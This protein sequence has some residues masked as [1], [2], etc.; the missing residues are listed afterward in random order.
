MYVCVCIH[1]SYYVLCGW[2]LSSVLVA[3][4]CRGSESVDQRRHPRDGALDPGR[5]TG[6]REL[7]AATGA[8]ERS[9]ASRW[10][11][12]SRWTERS[13]MSLWEGKREDD[14]RSESYEKWRR[15]VFCDDK[16]WLELDQ[17]E[18]FRIRKWRYVHVHTIFQA[19]FWRHIPLQPP[20]NRFLKWPLIGGQEHGETDW[21]V[22]DSFWNSIDAQSK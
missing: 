16:G 6:Q 5:G 4:T 19:T 12:R 10:S 1:I 15:S 8:L 22:L 9:V 11:E 14:W 13:E 18:N 20:I 7:S 2:L 21:I 17:W 3:G